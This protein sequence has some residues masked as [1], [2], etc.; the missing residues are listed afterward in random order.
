MKAFVITGSVFFEPL[1]RKI[2]LTVFFQPS[3][4]ENGNLNN[5]DGLR[6]EWNHETLKLLWCNLWMYRG[7][8]QLHKSRNQLISCPIAID[9]SLPVYR[10]KRFSIWVLKIYIIIGGIPLL[11][12]ALLRGSSV[13]LYFNQINFHRTGKI[14]LIEILLWPLHK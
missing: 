12:D 11:P 10:I 7:T 9:T 1:T 3:H 13:N 5:E 2:L 6:K 4:S 8:P 14:F